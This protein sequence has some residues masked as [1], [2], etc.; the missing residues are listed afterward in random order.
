MT[1]HLTGQLKV[2]IIDDRSEH[3]TIIEVANIAIHF[4]PKER[5]VFLEVA[6]GFAV[7]V[8]LGLGVLL[9]KDVSEHPRGSVLLGITV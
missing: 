4:F 9:A 5:A 8:H 2:I 7:A 3:T 6:T 1:G